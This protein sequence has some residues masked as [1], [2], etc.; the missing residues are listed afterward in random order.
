MNI[1]QKKLYEYLL[2]KNG[3]WTTHVQIARDLYEY[4]GNAECC[5]EPK[6]FHNT[7]ERLAISRTCR[8]INLSY[9]F[10]KI[11]INS[12]KGLKIATE[13]EFYRYINKQYISI[14]KKLKTIREIERKA[15]RNNQIN[16][17][18]N[19]VEAFLKDITENFQID[20]DK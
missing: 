6:D 16:F 1:T 4:Y 18:G 13:E 7:C 17:M 3:E 15:K 12:S 9:E 19:F 10:D 8:S 5:L 14:F 2:N 11:I 20:I